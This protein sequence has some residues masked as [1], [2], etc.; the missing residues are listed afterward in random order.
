MLMRFM[1]SAALCATLPSLSWAQPASAKDAKEFA[2]AHIEL[3]SSYFQAGRVDVAKEELQKVLD[4]DPKH[5]QAHNLQGLIYLKLGDASRAESDFRTA[6]GSDP[7]N[8]DAQNNYGMLLCQSGRHAEGM[9]AFGR[10]LQAPK[11]G[12]IAQT[13]VNG[14]LC[15]QQKGDMVGAEKFLIKALEQEPFMPAALYQLA[16]VYHATG[17]EGAAASRLAAL[18][19]QVAPNASSLELQL[20]IS[21]GLG[22]PHEAAQAA[23]ALRSRFPQSPEALRLDGAQTR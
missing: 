21:Q 22:Q 14:G 3:A 11:Y 5:S 7:A 23:Q 8:G 17:R 1:L 4:R 15:L 19:Q 18:H 20:Q 16:R 6:I 2:S 12:Q 13:L 9:E 10:A